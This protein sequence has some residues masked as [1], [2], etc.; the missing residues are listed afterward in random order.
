MTTSAT[1]RAAW[2]ELQTLASVSGATPARVD[3]AAAEPLMSSQPT[4]ANLTPRTSTTAGA[5]AAAR[6]L[7]APVWAIPA[8]SRYLMV[9]RTP[10]WPASVMCCFQF[11]TIGHSKSL[12]LTSLSDI[13]A[14]TRPLPLTPPK[15]GTCQPQPYGSGFVPL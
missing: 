7:P 5:S 1:F 14:L 4:K 2:I 11:E 15:T 6:F 3:V 10:P 13:S 12:A 9:C 8:A